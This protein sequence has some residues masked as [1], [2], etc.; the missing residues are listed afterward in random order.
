MSL[1]YT[2]PRLEPETVEKEYNS[3]PRQDKEKI[4]HD[5]FG[6]GEEAIPESLEFNRDALQR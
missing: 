6:T 1:S 4:Q 2:G 3:L 5:L